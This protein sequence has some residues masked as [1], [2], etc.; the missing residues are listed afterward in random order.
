MNV[1]I[2]IDDALLARVRALAQTEG[3]SLNELIRR[4]LETLAGQTSG[5]AVAKQMRQLWTDSPGHSG[6]R[7]ITREEAY[8]G[9]RV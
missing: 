1:T 7:K 6:G 3:T 8:E 2:S 9:R 4:H 5:A